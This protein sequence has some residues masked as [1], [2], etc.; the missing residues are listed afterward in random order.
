[1]QQERIVSGWSG[2]KDDVCT[3]EKPMSVVVVWELFLCT[4]FYTFSMFTC[5]EIRKVWFSY[6]PVPRKDSG[7]RSMS[8]IC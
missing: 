5:E 1:M 3:Q 8:N 7:I 4:S 2:L 6:I